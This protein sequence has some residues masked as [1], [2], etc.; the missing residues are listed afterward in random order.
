LCSGFGGENISL[1]EEERDRRGLVTTM[2]LEYFENCLGG[3]VEF[4]ADLYNFAN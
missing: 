2:F 3:E 4:A 1:M